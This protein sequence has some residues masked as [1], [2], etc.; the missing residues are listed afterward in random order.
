MQGIY[1]GINNYQHMLPFEYITNYHFQLLYPQNYL[2]P[3]PPIPLD[4]EKFKLNINK[5]EN[6]NSKAINKLF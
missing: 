6:L 1:Y 5:V 2:F 4:K 3:K